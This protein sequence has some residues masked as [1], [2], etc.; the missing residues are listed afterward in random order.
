MN[1]KIE[2]EE[3]MAGQE[4]LPSRESPQ[5]SLKMKD[6]QINSQCTE[7]HENNPIILSSPL[8]AST[9][10]TISKSL[11]KLYPYLIIADYFLSLVTWSDDSTLASV[12]LIVFYSIYIWNFQIITKYFGHIIIVAMFWC[13]SQLDNYVEETVISHPTLDDI[14]H[15][16]DR[17]TCKFDVL[18][19]PITRL[20]LQNITK[21]F[22]TIIFFSPIYMFVSTLV[23][24]PRFLLVI[25]G[26]VI[27]SYQSRWSKLIRRSM[28]KFKTARLFVFYFT[29]LDTI[30][31]LSKEEQ[32]NQTFLAAVEKN[33]LRK[34]TNY[35]NNDSSCQCDANQN[36]N[37]QNQL[38]Y[39]SE[40]TGKPLEFSYVLYENQRRWIGIG[41]SHSMLNYERANWT[42]EFLNNAPSPQDFRLPQEDSNIVW[43]WVDKSWKLDTTNEGA[44]QLPSSKPRTT[45]S[46][47]EDAGFIYYDNTWQKPSTIDSFSKYTRRRRWIR[48]AALI[49][50][51]DNPTRTDTEIGSASLDPSI[52]DNFI[53]D[54]E[55]GKQYI[56]RTRTVSFSTTDTIYTIPSRSDRKSSHNSL[57]GNHNEKENNL[58][59]KYTPPELNIQETCETDLTWDD[60]NADLT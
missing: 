23:I 21:L 43:K 28:W 54:L 8:L 52:K 4:N 36:T 59:F 11:V 2:N 19:S 29:G 37:K 9:P 38:S 12:L 5:S 44:I 22:Y 46:P 32:Y 57:E 41:W 49:R 1:L 35:N 10:S 26:I 45:S 7:I 25:T 60:N 30:N 15:I 48:T 27:L 18:L 53:D 17:V 3:G 34:F 42:D 39:G 33:I 40:C 24:P 20:N 47:N 16:I 56:N 50:I 55:G 58:P 31:G 51:D 6:N 14:I 13:Y